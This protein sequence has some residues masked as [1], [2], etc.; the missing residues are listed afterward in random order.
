MFCPQWRCV[1]V[2][3]LFQVMTQVIF[4][5]QWRGICVVVLLPGHDTSYILSPVEMCVVVLLPGHDTSYILSPVEGCVCVVVLLPGHDTSYI[6]SPVEGC[7]CCSLV[8]KSWHKLQF[9]PSGGVCVCCS[10]VARSWHKLHFV[11]SGGGAEAPSA[12]TRPRDW[13]L[14]K[15]DLL[16]PEKV[17]LLKESLANHS[18]RKVKCQPLCKYQS[19][20]SEKQAC[21]FS[22]QIW[23]FDNISL[24]FVGEQFAFVARYE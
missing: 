9:A 17:S 10:L 21:V 20:M 23:Y 6:L 12:A 11:P 4:C 2:V 5:P 3:V 15:A 13:R 24:K 16:T 18:V 7:V 14:K 22:G 1:C 8:A 19:C